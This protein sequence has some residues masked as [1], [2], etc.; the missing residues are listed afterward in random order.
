MPEPEA[1]DSGALSAGGGPDGVLLLHGITGTPASVGGLAC[2][3]AEAGFAVEVP[4]LPG[5]GT[6]VE[7]LARVGWDEWTTAV[8]ESYADLAGRC[9][10][11]VV[12]GLSM[13]GT[14]AC[15]LASRRPEVAG[16]VCINPFIEPPAESFLA[17][18]RDWLAHGSDMLP[19]IGADIARPDGREPSYAQL[20]V[21]PMLSLLEAV[22][23]LELERI[24][25]PLLLFTSTADHVV[26]PRSSDMLAERVSGP[27]GRVALERSF[28][29]ATLD[30]D[31]AEIERQA[32][33]FALEVTTGS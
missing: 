14:L 5:H 16:L 28:H 20:P 12:A 24:A 3:L 13:G 2:A 33:A 1:R 26:P 19:A 31:A 8:D 4:L 21:A 30:Y 29:V 7:D 15:W 32:V 23:R 9:R 11:V 17:L 27:V 18:L 22:G 10:R 6:V 25:C